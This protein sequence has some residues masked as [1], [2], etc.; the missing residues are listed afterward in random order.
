MTTCKLCNGPCEA[1]EPDRVKRDIETLQGMIAYI[2]TQDS[3][4]NI[5]VNRSPHDN[6]FHVMVTVKDPKV[7]E[8]INLSP[9]MSKGGFWTGVDCED[10]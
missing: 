4:A 10:Q 8:R 1:L 9:E 2:L 7:A 3:H 6:E 5:S